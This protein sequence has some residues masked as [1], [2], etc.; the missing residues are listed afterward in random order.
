MKT[1]LPLLGLTCLLVACA[2]DQPANQMQASES[3]AASSTPV[4]NEGLSP[5]QAEIDQLAQQIK[6]EH[7]A[8]FRVI[9]EAQFDALVSDL[10]SQ[11]RP[12]YAKRDTLWAFSELLA[13]IGCAHTGLFYF[14]AQE[15]LID[16]AQRFPVD[17]RY[18][19]GSLYVF[20]P[21]VNDGIVSVGDTIKTINGRNVD[22]IVAEIYRHISADANLPYLKRHL[23]NVSATSYLTYALDF[24]ESYTL[25]LDG[26]D[27]A[28]ELQPLD[29][30]SHAPIVSPAHTCQVN[31]CYRVDDATDTGIMT[32][33]SFAYYGASGAEFAEFV[34][35]AF[36]D[37]ITQDRDNLIID[38]RDNQG[39]SGLAAAY[40]LRHLAD[41]PF[42]YFS[43]R[44]DPRGNESLFDMQRPD[45][46]NYDGPTYILVNG[47]TM[48]SAP[49]FAALA[50]AN[51]MAVLIG[52][53]LGGNHATYDGKIELSAETLD[54]PYFIARM[55]FIVEAGD[56]DPLA[57]LRPHVEIPYTVEELLTREDKMLDAVLNKIRNADG[58]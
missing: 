5:F 23:F 45:D 54:A 20:D 18:L 15:K 6:T 32:I 34:D 12:E 21:L 38:I 1:T 17:V 35:N 31:L 58:P 48:S 8:P 9:E 40:V 26:Q 39:G 3:S 2:P 7:P 10:K 44:S 49:H 37:L 13:S 55:P 36:D 24:P 43:D 30:F 52:E 28:Q 11:I 50:K 19:D 46:V 25:T 53:P 14:N 29:S 51:D 57:P 47:N 33:R 42:A 56:A 16:T 4:Q 22:D 41:A 27:E